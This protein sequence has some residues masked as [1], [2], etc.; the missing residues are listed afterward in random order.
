M[1]GPP[2]Y[3]NV[4]GDDNNVNGV[5]VWDLMLLFALLLVPFLSS[6]PRRCGMEKPL[7]GG[8]TSGDGVWALASVNTA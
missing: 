2:S 1:S 4:D 3:A 7:G 6:M 5:K 8:S